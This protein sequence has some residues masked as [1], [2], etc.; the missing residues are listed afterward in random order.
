MKMCKKLWLILLFAPIQLWAVGWTPTDCGLVL[1]FEPGDQFLL[2][3]WIDQNKNGV[4]DPGEEYFVCDYPEYQPQ[5]PFNYKGYGNYLKLIPQ[6]TGSTTPSSASIWTVGE[7]LTRIT[8]KVD[9]SLGGISYTIWSSLGYTLKTGLPNADSRF[10]YLGWLT[11]KENDKDL[12]D[13]VF[14]VPTN[15]STDADPDHTLG[16]AGAFDGAMGV[17]FAGMIYREVYMFDIPRTNTPNVYVNA[18]LVT[19]N[20][21]TSNHSWDAGSIAPGKAAYAFADKKHNKTHRT[22]FR[23]YPLNKPFSSC[24][25]YFFGW[26]VQDYKRYRQSNTLTDSTAARKIYTLD[27]FVCMEREGSTKIYKT[28]NMSIPSSDSTYFY[29]GKHNKYYSDRA[30]PVEYL[31]DGGKALSQFTKIRELRVKALAG[32]TETYSPAAGAC[33]K[34]VVDTTSDAQNLGV[35]FEPAGYFLKV[36]TGKNVRMRQ[37]GEHEWTCDEMWTISPEWAALTIKATLMTGPE[38]GVIDTPVGEPFVL[39]LMALLYFLIRKK[40]PLTRNR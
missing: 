19:F 30:L 34:A 33:G 10:K 1:N 17:G 4:E 2:S 18:S 11:N 40:W 5:T 21:T 7:P 24:D 25:S 13:V 32:E 39:L 8:N 38:I 16:H 36:S 31:N 3:V 23:I 9:Y 22:L 28:D 14:A 29:V 37:T 12:C 35:T 6:A 20:K 26:D 27:H 15:R